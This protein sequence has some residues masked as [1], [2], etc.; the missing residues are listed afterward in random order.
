MKKML[1]NVLILS[2][3]PL[4]AM[5][6]PTKKHKPEV[7]REEMVA[8]RNR[9]LKDIHL[10]L[11][12]PDQQ[13]QQAHIN[14]IALAGHIDESFKA[15]AEESAERTLNIKRKRNLAQKHAKLLSDA[16][17]L[18]RSLNSQANTL[19]EASLGLNEPSEDYQEALLATLT[20]LNS[21]YNALAPLL[22]YGDA[23]DTKQTEFI[24]SM[25]DSLDKI[26]H[27]RNA[28]L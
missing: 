17:K 22:N 12:L 5:Y 16:L 15:L 6:K 13:R 1:T 14:D 23:R 9:T 24:Q 11:L 20:R 8:L 10:T 27:V 3:L 28:I 7:T 4:C 25:Q 26:T 19:Y 21:L 18:A 2:S